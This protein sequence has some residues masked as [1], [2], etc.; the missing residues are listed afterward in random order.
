M[1]KKSWYINFLKTNAYAE[2]IEIIKDKLTVVRLIITELIN[3][4]R[5]LFSYTFNFLKLI[6]KL[7]NSL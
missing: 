5:Y 3:D 6:K 4:Y 2:M 1:N 7:I